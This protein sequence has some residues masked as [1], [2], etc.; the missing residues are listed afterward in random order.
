[1]VER[2]SAQIQTNLTRAMARNVDLAWLLPRLQEAIITEDLMQLDLLVGLAND[3]S[4]ALPAQMVD[5]II[6]L[7]D[8]TTGLLARSTA[9]GTCA[10]DITSCETLALIGVCAVPFELSPAGDVNA[11]RRA[12]RDYLTGDSVDQLDVGLAIVGLGA[13]VAVTASGGSSYTIKAGT[14]V[15]RMAR[16]LGTLTAPLATRL[17]RLIGDAVYWERMSD[18]VLLR[19]G[20]EDMINT[21]KMAELTEISTSLRRVAANTSTGEAISLMRHVD[22]AQDAQ[23]LAR[24]STALGPKTR[25][26]F[27][28]LGKSRVFRAVVRLSD[29][30]IGAAVAIYALALQLLVFGTQQCCNLCARSLRKRLK[31]AAI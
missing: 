16:R 25:G 19:I 3:F 9:C 4:V 2:T 23:N 17:S 22:S 7:D 30:A 29:L 13:T 26:A 27:E 6:T 18:L 20:P 1:M 8:A 24:I 31:K 11:L 12:G 15:L 5:D 28:V 14:S 10:I 21:A